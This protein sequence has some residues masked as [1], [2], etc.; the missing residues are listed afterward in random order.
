MTVAPAFRYDALRHE[1]F[2][3]DVR[4]PSVTQLIELGGLVNG[5][6]YFTEESRRRGTEVHQLC[7]DWELGALDPVTV[8]TTRRPYLLGYISAVGVLQ[9]TWDAIEEAT[10][11]Q[12]YRFGT[13][14]DRVGTVFGKPSIA[15]IKS[16]VKAKHHAVQTALQAIAESERW[17]LPAKQFQRL[18]IYLTHNGKWS[19]DTHTDPRDF[20]VALGLIKRFC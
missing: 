5:S 9:P 4:V 11:S 19:V 8:Q 6:A 10:V 14:T 3:G 2:I 20:D 1:Y 15:E 17:N 16:A 12:R 18:T 7:A 13:R